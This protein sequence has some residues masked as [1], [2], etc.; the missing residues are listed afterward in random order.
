MHAVS[1]GTGFLISDVSRL[2]RRRFDERARLI[3]VTRPQWRAL[4][5]LYRHE[6]IQQGALAD[7]LEVEPITLCRMVDRMADAGLIERRRHPADRRV[8]KLYLTDKAHPLIDQ[9]RS[10]ADAVLATALEGL[11]PDAV[12]V[13][14]ATLDLVRL[15]LAADTNRAEVAHG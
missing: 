2:L 4:I 11:S 6:G 5:T 9:L 8:W 13:F 14:V 7:L 3:G 12:D 15:N 10:I 1:D